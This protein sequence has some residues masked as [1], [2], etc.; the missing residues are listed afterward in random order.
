LRIEKDC[1]FSVFRFC[2]NSPKLANFAFGV[3]MG[4]NLTGGAVVME[5]VWQEI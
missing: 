1:R 2:V 3:I 4:R 5:G